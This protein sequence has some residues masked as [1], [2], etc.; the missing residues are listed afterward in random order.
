MSGSILLLSFVFYRSEIIFKGENSSHYYKYY[1]ITLSGILFWGVVLRLREEIRANIVTVFISLIFGL[2]MAEVGLTFLGLG[3]KKSILIYRANAAAAELGVKFDKRTKLEVIDD[4][5]AEGLDA[6]PAVHPSLM[7]PINN[8]NN[9]DINYLMPLGG[10]GSKTTIYD[11]ESGKYMIYMSDRHGFN[12]PDRQWDLQDIEWLLLG[13]SFTQGAA[14]QAGEDIA[15]QIRSLTRTNAISLGIGGNGPLI[16]YASL[17]EYGN[18]LA[19]EKV[20]WIYFEGN[21]LHVDLE[22]EKKEPMLMKY[23]Q[24][25]FSQNLINRQKEID[26]YLEEYIE[27]EKS[28]SYKL[29]WIKLYAIRSIIGFDDRD[30]EFEYEYTLFTE[31]LTKAKARVESWGGGLF[32]VYLPA[33]E[34]YSQRVNSHDNFINKSEVINLVKELKIPVIDIH[35]EVFAGHPDPL[36]LFPFRIFGHYT[37]EGYSEVTEAIIAN[38][39]IDD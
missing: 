11:N 23:M 12:N 8:R 31:I 6:V 27:K 16:Q 22:R 39:K 36:S 19:P 26:E 25:D 20:L 34:R 7:I 9:T 10:V 13:D 37:K 15:G 5:V 28:K 32:F 17:V 1:L 35:K 29:N 38:T 30:I 4:L 21:D 18:A 24:D 3:G 33:Y 2:Y 14:V